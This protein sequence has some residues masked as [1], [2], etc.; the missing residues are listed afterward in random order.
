MIKTGCWRMFNV[1]VHRAVT[2][3]GGVF[4]SQVEPAVLSVYVS[5]KFKS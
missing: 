4:V 2:I 3:S 5:V 1:H